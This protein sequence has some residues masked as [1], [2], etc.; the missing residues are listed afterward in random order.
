MNLT[1]YIAAHILLPDPNYK[2]KTIIVALVSV[3]LVALVT[4]VL[5]LL[6][7]LYCAIPKPRP[8][9]AASV[10]L[11]DGGKCTDTPTFELDQLKLCDQLHRGRYGEVIAVLS[12]SL[13]KQDGQILSLSCVKIISWDF[14]STFTPLKP[15]WSLYLI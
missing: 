15:I 2:Q 14:L 11:M 7:R 8:D 12:K 10:N 4:V 9:G 13:S 6:Y 1:F 5:Y 3:F